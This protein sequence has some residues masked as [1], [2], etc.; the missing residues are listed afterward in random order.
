MIIRGNRRTYALL[1]FVLIAILVYLELYPFAFRVP[2]DD[3]GAVHKL[4]Q[5]W[6]DRPS[7]GDFLANIMAYIPLGFCATMSLSRPKSILGRFPIVVLVGSAL[8]M[9]F[10][11]VQYFVDGRVTA[12]T[13]VYANTIG[14]ILGST[15]AVFLNDDSNFVF[16]LNLV[17]KR[18]PS[19]LI[20]DWLAY[21]LYPYVPTTDLHKFWQAVKP[22]V[23]APTINLYELWRHT[24]IWLTIFVLIE[25]VVSRRRSLT[26][27]FVFV[28][29]LL[30]ARI[31]I[32]DKV[33]STAEV[34]GAGLAVCLWL[35]FLL[36]SNRRRAS[37]I[38]AILGSYIIVD[39]LQPFEFQD[40]RRGFGWLPFR[41]FLNGSPE[42]NVMAL[43]EKSFLYGALLYLLVEAGLRLR[44]S[45]VLLA[46]ALFVTSWA[47]TCLPGRSAEITDAVLVLLIASAFGLIRTGHQ[48][49]Q[50]P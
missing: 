34:S 32:V 3:G 39:R 33:L 6:A 46:C 5:S 45:A 12:A 13:D 27:A 18:V 44:D 28:A 42:I 24:A 31:S 40:T 8:S 2:H 47:E 25:A 10:E 20:L 17:E 14:V 41:S 1:T 26:G 16:R 21:R 36:M 23:L 50:S 22:L 9:V 35:V 48:H 29:C 19:Y 4:I 38:A 30:G 11:L 7:R 37:T 43:F 49:P 15:I